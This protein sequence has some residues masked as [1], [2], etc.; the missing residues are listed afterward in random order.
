M[1]SFIL[2]LAHLQEQTKLVMRGAY[3]AGLRTVTRTYT[4]KHMAHSGRSVPCT[5]NKNI[6]WRA[7][8]SVPRLS[9][10]E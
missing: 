8:N 3:L 6:M 10:R 1:V 5:G 9:G 4:R 2:Y 7:E